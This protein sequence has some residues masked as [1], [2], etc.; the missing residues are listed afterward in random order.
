MKKEKQQM[1][2]RKTAVIM[3]AAITA[4]TFVGCGDMATP[5]AAEETLPELPR[6]RLVRRKPSM[7][8]MWKTRKNWHSWMR[9]SWR[10]QRLHFG[11][12]WEA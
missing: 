1:I 8:K 11:T 9:M 4:G 12:L 3:A 6:R 10:E 2:Y 5:P 7:W